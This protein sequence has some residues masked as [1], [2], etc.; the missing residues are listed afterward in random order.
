MIVPTVP[1]GME[2]LVSVGTVIYKESAHDVIV[3]NADGKRL[4]MLCL[5]ANVNV[6]DRGHI[7]ALDD[8]NV[9]LFPPF[10]F[11]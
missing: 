8:G 9:F 1:K 10:P 5:F 3:E 4:T 6:G 7:I 2:G 11:L